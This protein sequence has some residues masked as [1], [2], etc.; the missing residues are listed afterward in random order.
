MIH[1]NSIPFRPET[2]KM[3]IIPNPNWTS[4]NIHLSLSITRHYPATQTESLMIRRSII[5]WIV[6][7]NIPD[8]VQIRNYSSEF[9]VSGA[10]TWG[11]PN[12]LVQ[13]RNVTWKFSKWEDAFII[14]SKRLITTTF[15]VPLLAV[16]SSWSSSKIFSYKRS[17]IRPVNDIARFHNPKRSSNSNTFPPV[18]Y[19]NFSPQLKFWTDHR[20]WVS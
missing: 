20:S 6:L 14:I 10:K 17:L 13:E 19:N 15:K 9:P 16:S 4:H 2:I 18:R 7:H 8:L 11:F 3:N 5:Q 12:T 1:F